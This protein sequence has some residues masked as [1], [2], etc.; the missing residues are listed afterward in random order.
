MKRSLNKELTKDRQ[1]DQVIRIHKMIYPIKI[2]K[3]SSI[4]C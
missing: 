4:S 2:I 1:W 3:Y